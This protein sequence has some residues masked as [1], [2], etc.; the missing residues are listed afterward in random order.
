M[1]HKIIRPE[2]QILL[3]YINDG[4]P[5]CEKCGALMDLKVLSEN[6][7]MYQCP[8]CGFE[9][10]KEEYEPPESEGWDPHM[11]ELIGRIED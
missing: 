4:Y 3:D 11:T 7:Y 2:G 5:I 6:D 10:E 9:I 8:G 1:N